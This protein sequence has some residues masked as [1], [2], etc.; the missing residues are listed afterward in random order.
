[1][2]GKTALVLLVCIL[3]LVSLMTAG[4]SAA[5]LVNYGDYKNGT[6]S[7]PG[8]WAGYVLNA[9]AG[10]PLYVRLKTSWPFSGQI[11][12]HDPNG[13]LIASSEGTYGTEAQYDPSIDRQVYPAGRGSRR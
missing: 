7:A 2:K 9:S 8:I 4:V 13:D 10:D 6:I 5:T 1:M 11:R 3:G 12:V